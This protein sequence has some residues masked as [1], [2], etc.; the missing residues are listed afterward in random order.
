MKHIKAKGVKVVVDE[1]SLE[2]DDFFNSKL[3][4]DIEHFKKISDVMVAHRMSTELADVAFK[5]YTRDQ[6]QRD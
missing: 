2:N 1:L 6:Y 5:V 3:I 4:K